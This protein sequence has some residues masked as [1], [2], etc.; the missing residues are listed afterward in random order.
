MPDGNPS[1]QL[2]ITL[3]KRIHLLTARYNKWILGGVLLIFLLPFLLIALT[4]PSDAD[5]GQALQKELA[6]DWRLWVFLV[7]LPL[8]AVFYWVT[9]RHERLTVTSMGLEYRSLLRGP[10]AFLHSLKPDW[11]L[12]WTEIQSASLREGIRLP[13]TRA[14]Q[15]ELVLQVRH[16]ETRKLQPYAWYME[17]DKNGLTLPGVFNLRDER[18]L[19][20]VQASP[21][22]RVIAERGLLEETP[23]AESVEREPSVKPFEDLPGGDF[24]LTSHPGMLALLGGLALVGGYALLDGIFL[25]PWRYLEAPPVGPMFAAGIAALTVALLLGRSAPTLERTT[26]AVLFALA[27]AGAA[28]PGMLRVNAAT[29]A[30]GAA[31]YRYR[32]VATGRFESVDHPDMPDLEFTRGMEFWEDFPPDAEREFVLARGDLGFWQLDLDEVRAAQRRFYRARDA[33]ENSR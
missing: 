16:G 26:L 10:L 3:R 8:A 6:E 22:Y 18:F 1:L 25:S 5:F 17:P 12:L 19:A 2:P 33:A 31:G 4:A 7:A 32:Q 14:R 11:R 27:S 15:R 23:E 28:H 21:L 30:D 29:D 13:R 24:D 20:A 9:I